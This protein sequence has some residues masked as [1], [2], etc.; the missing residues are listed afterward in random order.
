MARIS[1]CWLYQINILIN[2]SLVIIF[3][4]LQTKVELLLCPV[5][6]TGQKR[7]IITFFIIHNIQSGINIYLTEDACFRS[8]ESKAKPSF[9][10]EVLRSTIKC[11]NVTRS[12]GYPNSTIFNFF[13]SVIQVLCLEWQSIS[14][15]LQ[16]G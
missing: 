9:Y 10:Y 15:C 12:T 13:S 5:T 8:T 6:C 7:P 16:H 14:F 3:L 1:L 4:N 11:R 2:S